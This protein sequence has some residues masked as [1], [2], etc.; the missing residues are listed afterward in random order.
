MMTQFHSEL[1][2]T[3]TWPELSDL[4]NSQRLSISPRPR[5]DLNRA[6]EQFAITEKWPSLSDEQILML[7]F[8]LSYAIDLAMALSTNK[9]GLF[10][11]LESHRAEMIRWSLNEAWEYPGLPHTL[12]LSFEKSSP[13]RGSLLLN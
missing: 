12:R 10:P 2:E 8:R 13:L 7:Y 1:I 5:D 3:M 11:T 9:T 4:L 6:V